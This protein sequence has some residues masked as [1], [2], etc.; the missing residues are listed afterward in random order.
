MAARGADLLVDRLIELGVGYMFTLSG[1]QIL[2]VFDA[3]IGRDI[4]L[5]HTR[6]EAAAVHMADAWGRLTD[7]PGVALLTAGPGHCNGLSALYVALMEE[8]PV[9]MLSGQSPLAQKGRGAFQE[10]DQVAMASQ[11]TKASWAVGTT[12]ALPLAV[13][14]AFDIATSG[15]PGP[16]HLSLPSDVLEGPALAQTPEDI[17]DE[18]SGASGNLSGKILDSLDKSERPLILAGPAMGRGNRWSGVEN[19]R[20]LPEFLR[21]Q[22]RVHVGLTTLGCTGRQTV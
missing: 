8:S 22:W 1:N 5:I 20:R 2:S 9:V 3:T 19:Y 4:E 7:T 13:G 15:R 14:R 18:G 6:H 10:I 12:Y 11:V 16:V 17:T 21:S